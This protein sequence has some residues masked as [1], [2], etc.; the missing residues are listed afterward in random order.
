MPYSSTNELPESVRGH[1]PAHAQR[2]FMDAFNNAW[3][4]YAAPGKR[5]GNESREEAAF[6]VAWAAVKHE[7][8]K[9]EA[10]GDWEP[11]H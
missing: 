6:H 4:E 7:Y 5:R 8:R 10:T 2:I 11:K 9:D 3:D 1:L